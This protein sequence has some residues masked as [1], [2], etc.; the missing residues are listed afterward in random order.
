MKSYRCKKKDKIRVLT[1]SRRMRSDDQPWDNEN[2]YKLIDRY[3]KEKR[4]TRKQ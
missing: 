3:P 4:S 1:E 2:A